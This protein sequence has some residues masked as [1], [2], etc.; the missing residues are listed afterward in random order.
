MLRKY[1]E[2]IISDNMYAQFDIEGREHVLVRE[3][4]DHRSDDSSV[5]KQ[6]GFINSESDEHGYDTTKTWKI[7]V[8]CNY[9]TILY[10]K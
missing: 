5:N 1:A 2:N 3:F 9:I 8:T 4:I 10:L 6:D 7:L